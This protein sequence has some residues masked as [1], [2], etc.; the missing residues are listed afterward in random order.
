MRKRSIAVAAIVIPMLA[1]AT[2]AIAQ[3][4]FVGTWKLNLEKSKF[5][6]SA[7]LEWTDAYREIEGDQF[8]VMVKI[9]LP[10]GSTLNEV[11]VWPRQGGVATFLQGGAEGVTEVET[12]ISSNEW[13]ATRMVDGK[14]IGTTNLFVSQ[15][16]KTMRYTLKIPGAI[17]GEA[18]FDKQ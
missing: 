10:D 5:I 9:V 1:I 3:S 6:G 16:G 2:V 8:E 17:E 13:L 7:P 12:L 18:I 15:N 11:I 4:P 14:Q